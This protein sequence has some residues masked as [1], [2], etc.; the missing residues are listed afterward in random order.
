MEPTSGKN[1]LDVV[2]AKPGATAVGV[3]PD[4]IPPPAV[5]VVVLEEEGGEEGSPKE[6]MN[7]PP[8]STPKRKR[9]IFEE[10]EA[11]KMRN[12]SNTAAKAVKS[13]GLTRKKL[14]S[15]IVE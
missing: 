1:I 7:S 3:E 15:Q 12:F 2:L 4:Y 11:E 10:Y 5:K 13:V 9:G 8:I 6:V 14:K